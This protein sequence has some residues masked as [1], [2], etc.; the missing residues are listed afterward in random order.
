MNPHVSSFRK[1]GHALPADHLPQCYWCLC[2]RLFPTGV[3]TRQR[4][5]HRGRPHSGASDSHGNSTDHGPQHG[6]QLPDVSPRPASGRLVTSYR[7]SAVAQAP[8]GGVHPLG[9]RGLRP[10]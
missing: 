8:G 6:V 10:R 4:I 3:V 7:Q 2:T 5:P 9:C 1:D